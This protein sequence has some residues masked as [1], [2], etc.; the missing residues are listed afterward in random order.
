M[1]VAQIR[2]EFLSY[3]EKNGHQLKHSA[4]LIPKSDPTLL[5]VNAG[6]VPFKYFF[7]GVDKPA[8]Q[9][10]TSSQR[11]LRVGGKHNDLDNVGKTA[12]HHTLF[13]MLGNFSFG[14]YDKRQSIQYAWNFLTQVLKLPIAKLWVTVFHEDDVSRKIWLDEIGVDPKRVIDCDEVD[15][16]WSMGSHGPCGPCTEIFYDHG[17]EVAGGPPGSADAD[18][19]RYVEIWNIVFMEYNR[20]EDGTMQKLPKPCVDTGMGLE[21]IAAVMQNVHSNYEIDSFV[22]LISAYRTIANQS[23]SKVASQ[24]IADHMRAICWL[25][26]DGVL[27]SNEKRGYVLR[28]IIRRAL[29][30]AYVDGVE[31]PVLHKLVNVVIGLYKDSPEFVLSEK[32]ITQVLLQEEIAFSR[33]IDQGIKLFDKY[34]KS[35]KGSEIPG[36]LAFKLYDTYGFPLDLVEDLASEKKLTVDID[37]FDHCMQAQKMRSR[38]NQQFSQMVSMDWLPQQETEFV[39]YVKESCDAKLL[40]IYADGQLHQSLSEGEAVLVFDRTPFYAESGGQIGDIGIISGDTVQFRVLDTQKQSGCVLHIGRIESGG[41]STG[42]ELQLKI[43]AN[44]SLIRKNHSATH[45]LHEALVSVL[46][47]HVIQKG[48]LVTAD[49]LRFDFA[50]HKALTMDEICQV[51]QFVNRLIEKNVTVSTE[52]MSLEDAKSLGV[53]ALFD[54][55]YDDHVRV[56]TMGPSKELCG[57]THVEQTGDIALC[58]IVEQNAVS[59]GVRRIE[60]VT[61]DAALNFVQKNRAQLYDLA[62]IS[63]SSVDGISDK[64]LK[65]TGSMKQMQ[66]TIDGLQADNMRYACQEYLQTVELISGFRVLF[67]DLADGDPKL[68]RLVTQLCLDSGEVD[69]VVLVFGQSEKILLS[70]GVVDAM[71]SKIEA[72]GLFRALAETVGARGG[73]KKDFAQGSLAVEG[74]MSVTEVRRLC[75]EK[76]TEVLLK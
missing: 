56:L 48:S 62:K 64:I 69:V 40:C 76:L 15:N 12:R 11:C 45:L 32:K 55:K 39:G 44:R 65:L 18:G 14:A 16:F 47:D 60:A 41:L 20:S 67:V 2:A 25:I 10:V 51:E 34:V 22:E 73:G 68:L 1:K 50:H 6:M 19:D 52:L 46:G 63:Q 30:F 58:M 53:K 57:G 59:Q 49:R 8:F 23:V 61:A 35:L 36:D 43:D 7:L 33:T 74:A 5:F 17:P 70:V 29:R 72:I 38:Q 66:K 27:P 3:F 54:E 28:R 4:S 21:R 75:R 13:E 71:V 37:G 26:H 31:L 9:M 24:V 42:D